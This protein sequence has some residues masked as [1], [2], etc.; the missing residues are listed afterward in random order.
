MCRLRL[1]DICS[2]I[3]TTADHVV[4]VRERPDLALVRSNVRGACSPCNRA[5]GS[6]PDSVLALEPPSDALR[7]FE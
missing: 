7:I 3:S 5:R 6:L 1:P 4:S 2:R